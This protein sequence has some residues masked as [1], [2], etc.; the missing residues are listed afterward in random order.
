MGKFF[1]IFSA[2]IFLTSVCFAGSTYCAGRSTHY[3]LF[4][5]DMGIVPEFPIEVGKEFISIDGVLKGQR[6]LWTSQGLNEELGV[7]VLFSDK[8]PLVT[9]G[10]PVSG[11]TVF[12]ATLAV[13]DKAGLELVK[14]AVTCKT[15]WAMVP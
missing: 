4:Q 13:N 12:S 14:E 3:S 6:T 15:T 10:D 7:T 5:Y 11:W 2:N 8:V 1:L 9:E